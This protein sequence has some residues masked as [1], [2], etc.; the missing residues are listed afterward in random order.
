MPHFSNKNFS[1]AVRIFQTKNQLTQKELSELSGLPRS[2]V[3]N[4][5]RN[6]EPWRPHEIEVL[7]K[8]GVTLDDLD[9][10]Y[11]PM[12]IRALPQRRKTEPKPEREYLSDL[13]SCFLAISF[14]SEKVAEIMKEKNL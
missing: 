4:R 1:L 12:R 8:L 5:V 6:I 14:W 10:G 13:A 7:K 3:S 9:S 2:T 11:P